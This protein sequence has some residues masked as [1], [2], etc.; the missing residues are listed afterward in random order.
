[1][2]DHEVA[3]YSL[4]PVEGHDRIELVILSSD[5]NE[6]EYDI[7][8]SRS[9]GRYAF[10]EIDALATDFGGDFARELTERLDRLVAELSDED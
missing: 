10:E 7:P 2:P 9:S 1:M 6:W 4:R 3:E 8:Y 5:G